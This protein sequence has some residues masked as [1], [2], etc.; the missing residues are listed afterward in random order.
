[1]SGLYS[2]IW[3]NATKWENGFQGKILM[4]EQEDHTAYFG[5]NYT[6]KNSVNRESSKSNLKALKKLIKKM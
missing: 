3:E 1:M 4:S 2:G 6:L 5:D